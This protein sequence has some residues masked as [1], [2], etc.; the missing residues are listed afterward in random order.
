V[1]IEREIKLAVPDGFTLPD[2]EAVRPD[3]SAVDRGPRT[4]D[5]TYW[6]TER[7]A[8]FH[9]GIGLRHRT[10]DAATGL[11]TL[12]GPSADEGAAVARD[13]WEVPGE[14]A[15]IPVEL[16][17]AIRATAGDALRP[18]VR[19]RTLRHLLDL[20]RGGDV[21]VEVAHD[22]VSVLDTAGGVRGRF[23]EVELELTETTSQTLVDAVLGTLLAAGAVVDPTPKYLRALRALGLM[24]APPRSH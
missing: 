3:V 14:P 16:L 13:E 18:V 22:H 7:L 5:A 10:G 8:L 12:K 24:S 15:S 17:S 2:L 1:T 20:V 23:R 21:D 19:I 6:D 9:A 11:W 4:L